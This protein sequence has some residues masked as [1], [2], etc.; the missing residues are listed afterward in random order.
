MCGVYVQRYAI[1]RLEK[2][3]QRADAARQD[4]R[5]AIDAGRR[6]DARRHARTAAFYAG[7]ALV[8]ERLLELERAS[9]EP[10]RSPAAG[11]TH[12]AAERMSVRHKNGHAAVAYERRRPVMF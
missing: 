1:A 5:D 8:M 3:R 6:H 4:M 9:E 11:V 2:A 10:L 7:R 12:R